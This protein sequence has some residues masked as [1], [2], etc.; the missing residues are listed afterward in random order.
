MLEI[1]EDIE[2]AAYFIKQ[3]KLVIF[4]TETVYGLGASSWNE[5]ACL[6][7]YEVKG[8]P[9]DNP[10]IIHVGRVEDI[11]D[12]TFVHP[13]YERFIYSFSPGP[14]SFIL[15]KKKEGLFSSGLPTIGIRVPSF[16]KIQ[17][18]LKLAGPVSAPSANLSGKPSITKLNYLLETFQNTVDFLL[19]GEEPEIGIEST[20]IDLTKDVPV[21]LRPGKVSSEEIKKYL[22]NLQ[23]F[24]KIENLTP[25]SPGV[26]YKHYA[27]DC[28]V[29]WYEGENLSIL[30]NSYLGFSNIPSAYSIQV[31]DNLDYMKNLY[32]FF[33]E[34]DK[35]KVKIA[36]CEK[37]LPDRFAESILNR[38]EKAIIKR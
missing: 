28:L 19:L 8:R 9:K 33:I 24:S 2:K 5:I 10:F 23:I 26:K 15:A 14:I 17:E 35:R 27:P 29:K 12:L 25:L 30:E 36:Y 6:K 4:P 7:I 34:S 13:H 16:Q 1:S 20:V 18:F 31:Q 21:L 3:G 32:S 38:V 22:P 11:F 37:P